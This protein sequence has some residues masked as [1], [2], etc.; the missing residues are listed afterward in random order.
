MG[1]WNKAKFKGRFRTWRKIKKTFL[2]LVGWK[3]QLHE[4]CMYC[5]HNDL[6]MILFQLFTF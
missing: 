2:G 1:H 5:G 3:R 6:L 4:Q